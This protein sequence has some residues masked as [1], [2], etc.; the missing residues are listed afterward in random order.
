MGISTSPRG[1]ARANINITPLVDVVLVLLIVFLVAAPV[2]LKSHE[3]AIPDR[4]AA[5]LGLEPITVAVQGDGHVTI[6][7]DG[8]ETTVLLVDLA[9]TVRPML[10]AHPG[11]QIVL[12]VQPELPYQIAVETI[13]TLR[14]AGGGRVALARQ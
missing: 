1:R 5:G 6:G 2:L 11:R 13:D 4:D 7:A 14:S 3:I 10:D 9:A 12:D 8:R